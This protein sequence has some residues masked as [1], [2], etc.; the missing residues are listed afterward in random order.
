M[1]KLHEVLAVDSDLAETAKKIAA[2]A[3]VTFQKKADH[4]FGATKRLE[5]F[6]ESRKK[7]EEGAQESKELVSTVQEKLDY[8]AEHI[9]RHLDCLAQKESTNQVALADVELDGI[10]ILDNV[11]ATLLLSL[12]NKL[13]LFRKM[14]EG[15]PT[16][17]PGLEW[18]EDPTQREGVYK[19][20]HDITRH[21]TEQT[22]KSKILVEPT[23]E[24]PAQIEKWTEQVPIG[25]FITTQWSGMVSPARKSEL[26]GR[27]DALL[28][29]IKKARMRANS[30]EVLQKPIG[31]VLFDYIHA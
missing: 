16:L 13:A 19:A 18:I 9:V 3:L 2:E 20:S 28:R 4:F 8:V 23:K 26:L 30:T 17:A 15:I 14:Y 12:E 21:K 22:F 29:A 11:P 24:H 1:A 27:I 25:N 10:K 31:K 5:M 6:D 7:E